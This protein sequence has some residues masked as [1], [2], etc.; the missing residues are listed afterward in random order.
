MDR[1]ALIVGAVI[2]G[3]IIAKLTSQ[4]WWY[5]RYEKKAKREKADILKRLI[6][7]RQQPAE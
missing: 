1:L 6:T 4:A 3:P 2:L 5:E 7:A